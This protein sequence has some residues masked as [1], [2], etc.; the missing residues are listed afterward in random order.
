MALIFK[1]DEAVTDEN[2]PRLGEMF[3]EVNMN[4]NFIAGFLPPT[5][6][7][8]TARIMGEG[9]FFTDASYTTPA[10][11]EITKT[12][13]ELFLSAGTYHLGVSPKYDL[14]AIQ[15]NINIADKGCVTFDCSQ[16][17]FNQAP[18][19]FSAERCTLTNFSGDY[20]KKCNNFDLLDAVGIDANISEFKKVEN[21]L[22]VNIAYTGFTGDMVDAFGDRLNLTR[23]IYSAVV[24]V[25]GTYAQIANAMSANGR[26]SGSMV[27]SDNA[28]S[29]VKTVTFT[30]SGWTAT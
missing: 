30:A 3:W 13:S 18:F 19:S 9:N 28:G 17:K 21:I 2:L 1:L 23:L 25:T 24:G 16:L 12:T 5:D 22:Q 4:H 7:S 15:C 14:R 6:G 27:I 10:G 26:T 20:V 11:K 29:G 8:I